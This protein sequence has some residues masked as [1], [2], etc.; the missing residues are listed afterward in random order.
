[1]SAAAGGRPRLTVDMMQLE[2]AF[3]A[4]GPETTPYL[5]RDTGAVLFVTAEDE[6][7]SERVCGQ[8]GE[9]E[10]AFRQALRD[11]RHIPEWQKPAVLDA[12]HIGSDASDRYLVV[13]QRETSESYRDMLDFIGTVG[14]EALQERLW[15]AVDGRGAFRHFREALDEER[16]ELTRWRRYETEAQR[17]RI[18]DWL[19]SEGIEADVV[20]PPPPPEPPPERPS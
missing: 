10:F 17:R 12:F 7:A 2:T 8:A 4:A 16:A 18:L 3:E 11:N 14:D 9:S 13:P 19:E 20:L 5:D 1:M 6:K 15:R